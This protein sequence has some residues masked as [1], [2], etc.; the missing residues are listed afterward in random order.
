MFH[1]VNGKFGKNIKLSLTP[2]LLITGFGIV[3]YLLPAL[4]YTGGW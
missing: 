3:L 2:K 4:H 1:K